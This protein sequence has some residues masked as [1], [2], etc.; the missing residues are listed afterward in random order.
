SR[1]RAGRA[2]ALDEAEAR[3][4]ALGPAPKP[5][6]GGWPRP[7]AALYR[8]LRRARAELTNALGRPIRCEVCGEILF[9][10]IPFVWG[11][12]LKL[13]GA[14]TVRVRCDWDKMNRLSFRHVEAD[15][16]TGPRSTC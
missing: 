3:L 15:R 9:R 14:E 5:R 2:L 13:L 8:P 16:C 10:G 12:R 6:D 7:V 4:G 1:L 11:G